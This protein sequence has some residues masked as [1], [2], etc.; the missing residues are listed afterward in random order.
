MP[1]LPAD[2]MLDINFDENADGSIEDSENTTHPLKDMPVSPM[3]VNDKSDDEKK[4]D[5][6]D[7]KKRGRP[8]KTPSES[9]AK[10]TKLK[11]Q[12]TKLQNE[13]ETKLKSQVTK[14]QNEKSTLKK[15]N[16][17][18]KQEITQ[19]NV[20]YSC[21][22]VEYKKIH[23]EMQKL[24]SVYE[25][26]EQNKCD[27]QT[28]LQI[29]TQLL[30]DSETDLTTVRQNLK[31]SEAGVNLMK[32]NTC[33]EVKTLKSQITNLNHELTHVKGKNSVLSTQNTSAKEKLLALE[34]SNRKLTSQVVE[35]TEKFEAA[36]SSLDAS[37]RDTTK[38]R[39]LLSESELEK[40]ELLE[41]LDNSCHSVELHNSMPKAKGLIL[42]DKITVPVAKALNCNI[43]WNYVESSLA[44]NDDIVTE[45][46]A[47]DIVLFLTGSLEVRK[48]LKGMDA[49]NRLKSVISKICDK[50]K[51]VIAELPPTN[52]KG[53]A[54][55]ISLLNYKLS[56]LPNSLKTIEF[57]A[58]NPKSTPK[59]EIIDEND[60]LKESAT[61]IIC[62]ELER[63]IHPP[64][65]I[66]TQSE[67]KV[68][69]T[70]D[71]T[72]FSLTAMVDLKPNQI[73][74]VIGS[75]G[76]TISRLTKK[77]MVTMRIGKWSE[78]KRDKK[79]EHDEKT[80]AVIIS[81]LS[82]NVKSAVEAVHDLIVSEPD[83]A[84]N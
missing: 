69:Q 3:Q 31:D 5:N 41:Q 22:E 4:S 47:S 72:P 81:G 9:D 48:G 80:D 12:V 50:T 73:G 78:P 19:L 34:N 56:R 18:Q 16:E 76:S 6:E 13:K 23:D 42:F 29:T 65:T 67:F 68:P 37:E 71:Q 40:Q 61:R 43:K 53:A 30:E 2:E 66:K 45:M 83:S 70:V 33:A 52:Q 62:Q 28:E 54:G 39:Q 14:L 8:R 49:Y 26:L 32:K 46:I 11:S 25:D 77:H 59:H 35:L 55:Y 24:K 58:S 63:N 36:T 44:F 15:Q 27:L 7:R 51:V 57:I 82:N 74:R 79:T 64:D 38:L 17:K 84:R 10:E 21:I 75:Q 1:N 20:K 60:Q